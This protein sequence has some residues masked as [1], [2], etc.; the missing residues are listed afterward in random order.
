MLKIKVSQSYDDD[1][2][3]KVILKKLNIFE[4]NEEEIKDVLQL[5]N[6]IYQPEV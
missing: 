2:N 6:E 1:N 3:N 4:D 5:H